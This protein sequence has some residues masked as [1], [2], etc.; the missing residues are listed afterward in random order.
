MDQAIMAAESIDPFDSDDQDSE[1]A[2][3]EKSLSQLENEQ[4]TDP[5]YALYNEL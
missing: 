1:E 5:H 3:F 4:A 2:Q